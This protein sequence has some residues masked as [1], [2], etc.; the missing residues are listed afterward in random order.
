VHE[1][2]G[3]I[4]VVFGAGAEAREENGVNIEQ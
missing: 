1:E 3:E 2:A 4:N